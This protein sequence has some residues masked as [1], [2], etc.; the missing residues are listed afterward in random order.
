MF[1]SSVIFYPAGQINETPDLLNFVSTDGAH[2]TMMHTKKIPVIYFML[3][4]SY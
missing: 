3:L 1:C 4:L 2:E